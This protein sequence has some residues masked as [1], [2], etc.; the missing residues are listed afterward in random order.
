MKYLKKPFVLLVLLTSIIV[1]R[2][3]AQDS[4]FNYSSMLK[5]SLNWTVKTERAKEIKEARAKEVMQDNEYTFTGFEKGIFLNNP[6]MLD[7]MP[8]DY[9]E[10]SL[11]STGE[12]TVIKG[13]A[14]QTTEVPFRVYLRRNGS[15]V[16]IPGKEKSEPNQ[17]KIDITEILK[18][19]ENGDHVVIEAVRKEDGSV[20]R[21]LKLLYD[22]C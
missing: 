3:F 6:L 21:I 16:L 2:T 10:F 7:G 15:K 18:H 4:V 5:F 22:G 8:L 17:T 9:G 13:A 12:L 14:G 19:A 20:K 1:S 11:T